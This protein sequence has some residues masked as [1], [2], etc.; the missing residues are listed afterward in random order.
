[1]K[2]RRFALRLNSARFAWLS[3]VFVLAAT[4]G[5]KAQDAGAGGAKSSIQDPAL[6]RRIEVL[7]R[8][9]FN[10]PA[11]YSIA[12]GTRKPSNIPGY[13]SLQVTLSHGPRTS[14]SEF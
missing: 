12:F 2:E 10:V 13:D 14:T 4:V 5:C 6:A 7:V 3:M 1:M 11:E 9:Q 8:G